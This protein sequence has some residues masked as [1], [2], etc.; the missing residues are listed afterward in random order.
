M[1]GMQGRVLLITLAMGAPSNPVAYSVWMLDNG[2]AAS[3]SALRG[4]VA[5]CLA[6]TPL[7]S[8]LDAPHV[9]LMNALDVGT[10]SCR[11]GHRTVRPV[12]STYAHSFIDRMAD[13]FAPRLHQN[14]REV[15][16]RHEDP[17]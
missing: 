10:H 3:V 5:S 17:L 1:S 15:L 16:Y 14:V 8:A 4:Q 12:P 13:T 9:V 7:S 11:A 6:S 2:V